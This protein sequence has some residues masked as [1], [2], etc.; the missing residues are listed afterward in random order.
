LILLRPILEA[1]ERVSTRIGKGLTP[2]FTSFIILPVRLFFT[3]V[4]LFAA[5]PVFGALRIPS[6]L[7][8][9]IYFC[10]LAGSPLVS[11]AL[12]FTFFSLITLLTA[13]FNFLSASFL[14]SFLAPALYL[15]LLLMVLMVVP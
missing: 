13:L 4:T 1:P 2:L 10:N 6:F 15:L 12:R 11:S 3:L 9:P 8:A 14:A 5:F 7:R